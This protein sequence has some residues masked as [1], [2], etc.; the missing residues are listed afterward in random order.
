MKKKYIVLISGALLILLSS[1]LENLLPVRGNGIPDK[2]IRRSGSFIKIIITTSIDIIYKKADTIGITLEGDEN[3]LEY[4][5]TETYDNTLEIK[6][7]PGN[8]QNY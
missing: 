8:R 5:V 6:T 2:E 3:L 1:C 7:L 4:V